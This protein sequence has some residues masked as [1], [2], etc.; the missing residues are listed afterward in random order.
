MQYSITTPPAFGAASRPNPIDDALIAEARRFLSAAVEA[1]PRVSYLDHR[2]ARAL[3]SGPM[4][5]LCVAAHQRGA[6]IEHLIIA[7]KLAWGPL[8]EERQ[9]FGESAN[10]VLSAAVSVC[11]ESY[12]VA[13]ERT[14]AD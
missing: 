14:R 11:I 12:F 2:E 10:D 9:R 13:S 6:S 8:T 3:F 5:A 1:L 7:M 4:A